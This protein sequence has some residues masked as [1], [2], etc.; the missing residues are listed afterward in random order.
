MQ[1]YSFQFGSDDEVTVGFDI[2]ATTREQAIELAR[3]RYSFGE[4]DVQTAW[5]VIPPEVI[6][7]AKIVDWAEL[8][9]AL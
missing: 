5:V 2:V 6:T 9:A 1:R 4:E 8:D 3:E 7:D